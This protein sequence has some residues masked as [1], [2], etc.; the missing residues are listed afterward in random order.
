M[1][2]IPSELLGAPE[3]LSS[4]LLDS[5]SGPLL[6]ALIINSEPLRAQAAP[7]LKEI[8]LQKDSPN[9]VIAA[10]A[11]LEE[12]AVDESI[13]AALESDET[14]LPVLDGLFRAGIAWEHQALAGYLPRPSSPELAIL[15][16]SHLAMAGAEELFDALDEIDDEALLV[17]L[18]RA[19]SL[20][21][22]PDFF[23]DELLQWRLE[24][25]DE[26]SPRDRAQLD[27]CLAALAPLR[28]TRYSFGGELDLEFLGDDRPVA[29]LLTSRATNDWVDSLAVFRTVRDRDG[30]ELA[31]AFAVA[32]SLSDIFDDIDDETLQSTSPQDWIRNHPDRV[33]FHLI[34]DEDE[35]LTELLVEATVHQALWERAL[36][37]APMT[38]LPLSSGPL[39]ADELPSFFSNLG[40]PETIPGRVAILRSLTDLRRLIAL[41][42][43]P[44]ESAD[45]ILDAFAGSSQD[46]ISQFIDAF[47]DPLAFENPSD[48]GSRGLFFLQNS[49]HLPPRDALPRLANALFSGPLERAAVYR[50]AFQAILSTL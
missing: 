32:A 12:D 48:W 40:D 17:D 4:R 28:F 33:A 7:A 45:P 42:L 27:G 23:F 36:T 18:L 31:A 29:D 9:W 8:S 47:D 41:D 10:L 21:S 14:A 2:S 43:L 25:H 15:T 49:L 37:P 11:A 34:V 19:A 30:F 6:A 16:A 46:G 20:S 35:T 38:G 5:E 26:L 13:D 39:P 50:A 3:S 44:R 22:E 24:L 1:S